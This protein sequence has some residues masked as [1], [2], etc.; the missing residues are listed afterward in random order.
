MSLVHK[1][2]P[3][4]PYIW[5]DTL[6]VPVSPC[7]RPARKAAIAKMAQIYQSAEAVIILDRH[8][9]LTGDDPYQRGLQ[10]L[11][12]EWA[13]RLWTLQEAVL[14]GPGKLH[15]CFQNEMIPWKQICNSFASQNPRLWNPLDENLYYRLNTMFGNTSEVEGG[16]PDALL[17]ISEALR[18]RTISKASD[19]Y[20]CLAHLLGLDLRK[21]EIQP[22]SMDMVI[23]KIPLSPELIFL[24]G[25]RMTR[26]SFR[27]GP[28]SLLSKQNPVLAEEKASPS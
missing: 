18:G 9:Q 6:A 14:P 7:F 12:L 26:K 24:P 5:I 4:S 1:I 22:S 23:K 3:N 20:I 8:L 25:E 21:L 2:L 28:A 19:E 13:S 15:V 16:T 10:I 27:W 11:C 17:E